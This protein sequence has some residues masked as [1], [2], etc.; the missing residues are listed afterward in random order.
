MIQSVARTGLDGAEAAVAGRPGEYGGKAT[1]VGTHDH[2]TGEDPAK[3]DVAAA[4][5]LETPNGLS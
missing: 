2:A 1:V 3:G 5:G 4:E